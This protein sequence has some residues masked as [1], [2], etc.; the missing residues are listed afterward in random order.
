[1]NP[2]LSEL[3]QV[4]H[5]VIYPLIANSPGKDEANKN[6]VSLF[7]LVAYSSTLLQ[8]PSEF[9]LPEYRY[10]CLHSFGDIRLRKCVPSVFSYR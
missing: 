6:W 1:L 5:G 9:R 4:S 7:L 2:E 8:V 10:F 3:L